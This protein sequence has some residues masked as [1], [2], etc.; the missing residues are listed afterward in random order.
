MKDELHPET[1]WKDKRYRSPDS[2]ANLSEGK[3]PS[4]VKWYNDVLAIFI[5]CSKRKGAQRH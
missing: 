4:T 5:R 3:T 1:L 2:F